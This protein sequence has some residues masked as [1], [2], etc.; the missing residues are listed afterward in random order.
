M[1]C[2]S[3]LARCASVWFKVHGREQAP[4]SRNHSSSDSETFAHPELFRSRRP[5]LSSCMFLFY[6][7]SYIVSDTLLLSCMGVDKLAGGRQV[8]FCPNGGCFFSAFFVFWPKTPAWPDLT[9]HPNDH[10]RDAHNLRHSCP[11]VSFHPYLCLTSCSRP[12]LH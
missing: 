3:G 5:A 11:P 1:G 7:R 6:L 10:R 9:R 8:K 2:T 12:S 4:N